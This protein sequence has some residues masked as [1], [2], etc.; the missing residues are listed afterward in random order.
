MK[1]IAMFILVLCMM[2]IEIL[3]LVILDNANLAVW[4]AQASLNQS[5]I[6]YCT[7]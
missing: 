2:Q 6:N 4:H 1:Y 7:Q 5:F 3:M